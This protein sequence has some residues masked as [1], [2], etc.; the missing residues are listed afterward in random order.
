MEVWSSFSHDPRDP[1]CAPLRASDH[2]R[3]VVQLVLDE[4]YADGRLDRGE[5]DER[6]G[7]VGGLRLLGDVNGLL[8]DLVPPPVSATHALVH[9]SRS[10]LERRAEKA[11]RSRRR[12]ALF[13]FIGPSAICLA[14][15]TA[16]S[17]ADGSFDPYFFWPA[18]VIVFTFLHFL[19]VA[20]RH[21][22][23]VDEEIRRLEKR[24][25]KEQR[26]PGRR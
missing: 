20:T 12:E 18:F 3:T 24:R 21:D 22:E 9:A 17:F 19:R 10:D 6:S 15:W 16:T 26:K 1:R 5:Y 4:A 14:I 25:A 2:D 13:S 7:R 23:I 8:H 11:W